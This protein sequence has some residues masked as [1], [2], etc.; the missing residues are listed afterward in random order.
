MR[1]D[2]M[3]G[4]PPA[5][6]ETETIRPHVSRRAFLLAA[7]GGVLTATST[8]GAASSDARQ[9]P[10]PTGPIVDTHQ[11]LWDPAGLAPS[12]L[13]RE[14]LL[15]ARFGPKEYRQATVGLNVVQTVYMEVNMDPPQHRAE[16]DYVI[17]LCRQRKTLMRA[18][19]VGGRPAEPGFGAYLDALAPGGYVKGVRQ[20][21]GAAPG[22]R[23]AVPDGFI[24]GLRQLG[25]RGM[26]FD[27]CVPATCLSNG[28]KLV[29]ACPDTRFVLDHCGNADPKAFGLGNAKPSHDPSQWKRDVEQLARRKNVVCKI[30]GIVARAEPG[31][32][33]PDDLAPIVNHCLDAFGPQRV[34]FASDWPVCTRAAS[35]KQWV[36][37][38]AGIVAS[39]SAA[40]QRQLFHDNAVRFYGL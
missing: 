10:L 28:L 8:G 23:L 14:Q 38:L 6:H 36:G 5:C 39:R 30:S 35:L 15:N 22:G 7:A 17:G 37:A 25:R 9:W 19:V 4:R 2:T 3:P 12:W 33:T 32:W 18:A 40:Q 21:L 16:A 24:E 29:D 1:D 13:A 27:L 20:I 34:M 31:R 26:C 11:H